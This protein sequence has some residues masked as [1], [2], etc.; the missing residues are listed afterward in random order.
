MAGEEGDNTMLTKTQTITIEP[1]K[2]N[3]YDRGSKKVLVDGEEWGWIVMQSHGVHGPSYH[4]HDLF[5]PLIVPWGFGWG[6]RQLIEHRF[7]P[8]SAKH[9]RRENTWKP[10]AE[11][12][13][14]VSTDEQLREHIRE[15][16]EQGHLK[17][18]AIRKQEFDAKQARFAA[19]N[20]AIDRQEREKF[21]ARADAIIA[22]IDATAINFR[23][24]ALRIAIVDAMKWA[25][26][27]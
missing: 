14:P 26:T 10:E 9:V 7:K 24:D 11:Q 15:L 2:R 4:V 17:S 3:E 20:E 21:E 27:Q 23:I 16:I 22:K 18:P 13:K 25:Q 12:V 5:G 6:N 19:A 1:Y 8:K